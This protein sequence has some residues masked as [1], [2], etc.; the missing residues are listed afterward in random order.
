MVSDGAVICPT[1]QVETQVEENASNLTQNHYLANIVDM[2]KNAPTRKCGSCRKM[3]IS[4]FCKR[5]KK[6]LCTECDERIHSEPKNSAHRV[7]K[8]GPERREPREERVKMNS[9][10]GILYDWIDTLW[11]TP[12]LFRQSIAVEKFTLLYLPYYY[13]EVVTNVHCTYQ[14]QADHLS[15]STVR[16]G[17]QQRAE[18][19]EQNIS[20]FA[21]AFS[22]DGLPGHE[23]FHKIGP[24][25]IEECETSLTEATDI[26][27]FTIDVQ[28]C[29][30]NYSS[31]RI[32]ENHE[33]KLRKSTHERIRNYRARF[34]VLQK[35]SRR[36]FLPVYM[37]TYR[38]LGI[39]YHFAINAATGAPHGERPHSTLKPIFTGLSIIQCISILKNMFAET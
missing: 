23:F 34:E 19:S 13:F 36:V 11:M 10:E 22:T 37:C 12:F 15:T 30:E 6:F 25:S 35:K 29:W 33:D 2:I 31:H 4:A 17:W 7:R 14:V 18:S 3:Q 8:F 24:G 5:C 20:F 1:C 38:Y 39:N 9:C 28:Q 26:R 21:P 32:E 16:V 27:P